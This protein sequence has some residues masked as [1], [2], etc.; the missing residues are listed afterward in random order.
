MNRLRGLRAFACVLA[1]LICAYDA[2]CAPSDVPE[3]P[4]EQS[5]SLSWET[6]GRISIS[7]LQFGAAAYRDGQWRFLGNGRNFSSGAKPDRLTLMIKFNYS[8][9]RSETPLKFT[10]KLP[11]TRQYEETVRLP[12]HRGTYSY[13][14]TIHR[15]E[16]F[17]GA[18]SVYVYYGFR[19]VDVLDFTIT[20]GI[21]GTV[22]EALQ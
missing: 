5:P 11:D 4:S 1:F 19:L 10:I 17:L 12:L 8:G 15:L 20:P 9:A 3:E 7:D 22:G 18:G 14:F 16:D 2:A 21:A 13:S 6:P